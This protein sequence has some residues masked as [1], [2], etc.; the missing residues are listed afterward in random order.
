MPTGVEI[1][2]PTRE[3]LPEGE[4]GKS[5]RM[6]YC[7]ENNSNYIATFQIIIS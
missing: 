3:K 4:G 1:H 6:L 5:K 7:D 2:Y